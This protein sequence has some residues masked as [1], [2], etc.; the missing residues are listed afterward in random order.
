MV[1]GAALVAAS[2]PA[3]CSGAQ[4]DDPRFLRV[5]EERGK[6]IALELAARR[7]ARADGGGPEVC[8]VSVAHIADASLYSSLQSL[9]DEFDVVLYESVK[10]PGAGSPA[11]ENDT[12]RAES[13]RAA[14]TF[15][16]G[17]IAA[18]ANNVAGYPASIGELAERLADEDPR[19]GEW[20]TQA[21]RDAW[22]A[23]VAYHV[24][25]DGFTLMSYGANGA[26]GGE[27]AAADI[28]VT[29]AEAVPIDPLSGDDGLQAQLADALGLAF[30]LQ[31]IDYGRPNFRCS[32]MTLDQLERSL[33]ARGIDFSELSGTLAGSSFSAQLVNLLLKFVKIVD[34]LTDG[35][36]SD[37]AKLAM[38]E[39]LGNESLTDAA[40]NQ[41]F[42]KGFADVIVGERNQI[43]VDDLAALIQA[44][45]EV[46][47]VAIFYGAAHM[48]DFE[49][50][51]AEQ[52]QYQPGEARWLPAMTLDLDASAL[53]AIE[54]AQ[55]RM[56]LRQM[57]RQMMRSQPPD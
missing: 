38:I 49:K 46:K 25:G 44:E 45:P 11:G 47:S 2:L 33:A 39:V 28:L 41:Q 57:F 12:E 32:D 16:A 6:S 7:Y 15:L 13:T 14:M 48:A 22:G 43:V 51:L 56:M 42:G 52:L 20:A 24:D 29:S 21:A 1:A 55:T 5:V 37:M 53:S 31:A 3:E 34:A 50:R 30:Q 27:G 8:L 17:L 18:Q 23:E 10:P 9:L 36:M 35:R 4:E 54:I 40:L 19:L 26:G